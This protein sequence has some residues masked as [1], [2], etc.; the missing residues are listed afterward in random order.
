MTTRPIHKLVMIIPAEEQTAASGLEK[1]EP[2]G[3]EPLPIEKPETGKA[4]SSKPPQAKD[5]PEDKPQSKIEAKE[6][7]TQKVKHKE[8]NSRKKLGRQTRTIVVVVP[9]EEEEIK[10]VGATR[11]RRGRPRKAPGI[12]PPDQRKGS[13]LDPGKGVCA[14]PVGRDATLGVGGPGPQ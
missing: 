12:G 13:V 1:T 3:Q 10:D 5:I 11:R 2:K 7:P 6:K 4:E 14:D 8:I 9:K